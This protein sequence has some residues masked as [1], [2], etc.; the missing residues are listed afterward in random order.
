MNIREIELPGIGKKFEIET[1]DKEKIVI[2]VHD[3]GRREI[4]HFDRDD[5]E[6]PISNFTLTDTESR[7]LA[8]I[9]GGMIYKP[10]ALETIEVALHDLM[11]E[12]FKVEPGA[13]AVGKSIGEMQVRQVYDV[14]LIGVIRKSKQNLINPGP[15]I[16]IQEEDMVVVSGERKNL[17]RFVHEVLTK[18]DT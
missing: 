5:Y 3:D 4:Y 2:I 1:R 12:W 6:E 9:V 14:S 17:K 10:Q 16:V 15:E 18:G 8:A 11:I 7:Q 13:K